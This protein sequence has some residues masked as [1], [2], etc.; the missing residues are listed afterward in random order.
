VGVA[1][2]LALLAVRIVESGDDGVVASSGEAQRHLPILSPHP[3]PKGAAEQ[4]LERRY[5]G[6]RTDESASV[7][8]SGRIPKPAHSVRRCIVHYPA[9]IERRVVL[10]TNANGAEVLS[11]P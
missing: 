8:C 1:A 2:V 7:S 9:G 11:K 4:L 6:T 10:L 5:F 3:L